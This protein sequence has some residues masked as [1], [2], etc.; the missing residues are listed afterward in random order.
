M[1]MS[2]MFILIVGWADPTHNVLVHL[3]DY[4]EM[5]VEVP[6]LSFH[7]CMFLIW[8]YFKYKEMLE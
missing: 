8:S 6:L 1:S 5:I 3:N 2:M 7:F 4:G